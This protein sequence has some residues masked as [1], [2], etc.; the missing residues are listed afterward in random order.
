[1]LFVQI[2]K[3][4]IPVNQFYRV[5]FHMLT[6]QVQKREFRLFLSFFRIPEAYKPPF[7]VK[8]IYYLADGTR[9][10]RSSLPVRTVAQPSRKKAVWYFFTKIMNILLIV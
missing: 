10:Y 4:Q 6:K 7:E 8:H 9:L 1:V 3:K 5:S 2:V